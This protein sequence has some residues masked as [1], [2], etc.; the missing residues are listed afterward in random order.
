MTARTQTRPPRSA[1]LLRTLILQMCKLID[2]YDDLDT[3]QATAALFELRLELLSA[4][5]RARRKYGVH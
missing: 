3:L 2:E 1:E 4:R 5:R